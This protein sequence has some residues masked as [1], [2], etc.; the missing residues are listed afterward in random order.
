MHWK[1]A[2]DF[3]MGA[4]HLALLIAGFICS[5]MHL[6]RSRWLLLLAAGF[7]F[8]ALMLTAVFLQHHGIALQPVLRIALCRWSNVVGQALVIGGVLGVIRDLPGGR[9]R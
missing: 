1:F 4:I 2:V 8:Q 5:V 9:K 7:G 3:A 6:S